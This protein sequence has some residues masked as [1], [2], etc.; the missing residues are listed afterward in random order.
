MEGGLWDQLVNFF[1]NTLIPIHEKDDFD[2]D[3]ASLHS[4]DD[5]VRKLFRERKRINIIFKCV[6]FSRL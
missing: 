3:F 5:S 6:Y 4:E 2:I 1:R